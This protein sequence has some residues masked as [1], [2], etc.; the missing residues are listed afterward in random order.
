MHISDTVK[1]A[2]LNDEGT[3]GMIYKTV[4]D[5]EE[6]NIP[7]IVKF[8]KRYKV[9]EKKLQDIILFAIQDV[10]DFESLLKAS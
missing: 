2:L 5:I 1:R 3:L 7:E 4:R 6:I 8:S 9:S 10:N